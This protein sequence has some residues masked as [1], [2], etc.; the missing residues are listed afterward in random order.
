MSDLVK[1]L[2]LKQSQKKL[3]FKIREIKGVLNFIWKAKC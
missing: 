1:S 2:F 3:D